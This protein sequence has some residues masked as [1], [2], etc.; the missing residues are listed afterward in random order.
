MYPLDILM[1]ADL[2][3]E[4]LFTTLSVIVAE[5]VG[6]GKKLG[7]MTIPS[8]PGESMVFF[9]KTIPVDVEKSTEL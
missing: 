8:S 7:P 5:P 2:P 1:N 3:V 4:R 9:S 6:A